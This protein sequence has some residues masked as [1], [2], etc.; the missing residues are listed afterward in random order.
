MDKFNVTVIGGGPA[1]YVAAIR[2]S[3]LGAKV[4]LVE[5]GDLGGVCLN[6]GCVPTKVLLH[7]GKLYNDMKE[8]QVYGINNTGISVEWPRVIGRKTEIIQQLVGGVGSLLNKNKVKVINGAARFL[9]NTQI[10]VIG[11]NSQVISSDNF[12]ICS[13]SKSVEL[14]L[15]G[16]SISDKNVFDSTSMLDAKEIPNSLII[17][18][19][20]VIGV[21]FAFIFASLGTKVTI[22]EM[23]PQLIN[24]F[25]PEHV[26]AA[27][28]VLKS[29]GVDI[30]LETKMLV[31]TDTDNGKELVCSGPGQE[32]LHIKGE[33]VL[34]A[35]GR[36]ASSDGMN[37]EGLNIKREKGAIVVNEYFQ[38]SVP[39]IYA[40]GD[41][42][43]GNLLAYVAYEEGSIAAENALGG[44]VTMNYKAV[45]K[46]VF[47]EPQ[48]SSV[49]LT[50]NE[51]K[52]QGI[53]VKVGTFHLW[54][55]GK[56]MIQNATNG[57]VKF[58]SESQTGE[59]LGVHL[60]TPA[61]SELIAS[62]C[63]ALE[64]ESTVEEFAFA[65]FIHP[66]VSET[67]KEAGL[68]ALGRVLHK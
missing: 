68:D 32:E 41:C 66:T 22:V 23:M 52:K 5:K 40:A 4:C 54:G 2:A 8:S 3:Q 35:V 21:E 67:L 42:I 47:M 62:G 19:G 55:N 14:S 45:P 37:L 44:H 61:A 25:E 31:A 36:K 39:N 26:Q 15:Q 18:G 46:A 33:A 24:G 10:E 63:L 27:M 11:E 28:S 43:G 49:G 1:G 6:A 7:T 57:M 48:L 50:E 51:A 30:H 16:L 29:K 12:I 56:A 58:V 53:P 13:G 38:T 20:G 64:L 17:V 34:L 65:P 60:F 9:S 59:L